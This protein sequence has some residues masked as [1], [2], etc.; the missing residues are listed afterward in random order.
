MSIL[1]D[2]DMRQL[3]SLH[4]LMIL[5]QDLIISELFLGQ[6]S[7]CAPACTHNFPG[8]GGKSPNLSNTPTLANIQIPV[9]FGLKNKGLYL[10]Q[11]EKY[12]L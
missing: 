6:L 3:A 8:A 11:T 2:V 7:V 1:S 10:Y 12:S 4:S 5:S 9:M